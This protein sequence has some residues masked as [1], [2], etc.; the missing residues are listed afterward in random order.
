M[1]Q[2]RLRKKKCPHKQTSNLAVV[3]YPPPF[4]TP[5]THHAGYQAG[6]APLV[7][8]LSN[9]HSSWQSK[10]TSA[11]AEP[12]LAS[13]PS[14]WLNPPVSLDLQHPFPLYFC[15]FHF[16]ETYTTLLCSCFSTRPTELSKRFLDISRSRISPRTY[17]CRKNSAYG[18]SLP[19]KSS[20]TRP[21]QNPIECTL[22][23]TVIGKSG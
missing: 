10:G 12:R 2:G 21:K 4:T 7:L 18:W 14:V 15:L 19:P 11:C 16:M 1:Q 8:L 17:S 20:L 9:N 22:Y 3:L 23:T 13:C 6:T 5:Q